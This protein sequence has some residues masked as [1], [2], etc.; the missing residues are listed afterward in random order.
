MNWERLLRGE[1]SLTVDIL[2]GFAVGAVVIR[3]G[4]ADRL[5]RRLLPRLK[6][7]GIGA[8]LGA[9]L[10]VSV[11][12]SKAGAAVVAS[13]LD[14]GKISPRTA[15]WGTLLLAF[16]AYLRRWVSTMILACSLAHLA[17]GLFALTLLFRSAAKFAL[18]LFILNRGE[19]DDRPLEELSVA[20]KESAKKFALRLL[21]TLPWAWLFY[22]LAM[23]LVPPTERALHA[24]LKGSAFIPLPALAVAAASFAHVSAALALAGGSLAAGELTTAQAVFALLLG[25]S[26]SLLTRLVR[27]NAGY[28]F[29]FFPRQVAQS[30]LAW[31]VTA[32]AALGLLTLAAAAVPLLL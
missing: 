4:L 20:K 28:Y 3:T 1:L 22:A 11:G 26:L 27:T 32:S 23:L 31:N 25:N 2:I 15:K 5:L 24:W 12:S 18:E 10:T 16:P 21:K 14:A 13:A 8:T 29:G 9:A 30:M 17:G 19:H 7:F 6:R